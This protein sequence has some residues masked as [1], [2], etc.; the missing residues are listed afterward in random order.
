MRRPDNL[1][2][3]RAACATRDVVDQLYTL[4]DGTLEALRLRD[5]PSQIYNCDDTGF[6]MERGTWLH[7][8]H[9]FSV[10]QCGGSLCRGS[11]VITASEYEHQYLERVENERPE[12][13]SGRDE[14]ERAAFEKTIEAVM[15]GVG[16]TTSD[17]GNTIS[18]SLCDSPGAPAAEAGHLPLPPPIHRQSFYL[19]QHHQQLLQPVGSGSSLQPA[20][21][22]QHHLPCHITPHSASTSVPVFTSGSVSPTASTSRTPPSGTQT[23]ATTVI[24]ST[25]TNAAIKKDKKR[26]KEMAGNGGG[27]K[28]GV[29]RLRPEKPETSGEV[30]S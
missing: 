21:L 18:P 25:S 8:Y 23:A 28:C 12:T 17:S 15:A 14:M 19:L 6:A 5:K 9:P 4:L 24:T 29:W 22:T 27:G 10:G 26:K 1:N 7:C 30:V 13:L 16:T 3:A 20:A 2:R 11:P